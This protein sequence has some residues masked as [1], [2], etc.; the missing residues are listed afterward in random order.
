MKVL[1][2]CRANLGRSQIASAFFDQLSQHT[3]DSAGTIV[4]MIGGEGRTVLQRVQDYPDENPTLALLVDLMEEEGRGIS[5]GVQT[6]SR[7]NW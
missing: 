7:P 6:S 1:F 4:A 2:V 5:S 3:P